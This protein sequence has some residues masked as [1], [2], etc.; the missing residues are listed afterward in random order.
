MA[1]DAQP[2][3]LREAPWKAGLRAAKANLVP[4]LVVQIAMVGLLVG[5]GFSVSFRGL[6]ESLA[7]VKARWGWPY[8]ALSGLVAGGILPELLR[9]VVFQKGKLKSAN[10][11]ELVFAAPFWAGMGT[12][13]DFFYRAQAMW[14]GDEAR[15]EVVVPQVLVD[16]FVY[17]PIFAAPVTVWLYAWKNHGYRWQRRFFTAAFYRD[18]VVPSLVACWGVWIPIVTVLYTLPEPVQLPA[19]SLALCLWV[20]LYGWMAG[21]DTAEG[22]R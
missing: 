21:E 9:V 1:I 7:E 2:Q 15:I 22:Q 19:F 11:R 17:N 3:V 5:Y 13:V 8:S 6:L 18:K 10:A 4:G 20:M 14:F 16:Q 12:V